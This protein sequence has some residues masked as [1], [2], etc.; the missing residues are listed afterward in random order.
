MEDTQSKQQ[1]HTVQHTGASL[2]ARMQTDSTPFSHRK[3]ARTT[4]LT[5][6]TLYGSAEGEQIRDAKI[7]IC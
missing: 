2:W 3:A 6:R 7:R 1:R 5:T 4:H